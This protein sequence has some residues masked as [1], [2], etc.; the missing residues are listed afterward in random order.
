MLRVFVLS[1]IL[2]PLNIV[3]DAFLSSPKLSLN[4]QGERVIEFKI[5]S[6]RISDEDIILK[7]Y[8]SNELLNQ[9]N[10][11]Y[12]LLEDFSSYKTYSIVLNNSYDGNYFNFKLV[13][14]DQISKDIFIFLPSKLD[15]S[16]KKPKPTQAYKPAIIEQSNDVPMEILPAAK[17]IKKELRVIKAKEISTMWSLATNIKTDMS[18]ASIYQIMWSIYLGNKDAFIDGNINLVRNDKDL[19][20]PSYSSISETSH[21][22]AKAS[23][24]AM[25]ESYSL[26][27]APAVKSLLVLTAPKIIEA[28][29]QKVKEIVDEDEAKQL[30]INNE[31]LNDPAG[32]IK[33]NTKTLEMAFESKVAKELIKETEDIKPVDVQEFGLMDLLFVAF[34][35]I[36]SGILIAL[37]YIQLKSRQTKKIDYDFDEAPDTSSSVAGLPKGLSI[38]NN[39]EEQQLDLAVTY[40]EMGDL[41]NSKSI[42]DELMKST[43][44]DKIKNDAK[45][46]LDKFSEK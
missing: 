16:S 30:D 32:I 40:F 41:E 31:E 37:I 19:I 24:L 5:Q 13:I 26:S 10:I 2:L 21:T 12:T 18:D 11:S 44:S 33:N 27:I 17:E 34:V 3:A 46:L 38:R 4:S 42:L 39:E 6:A 45:T 25:N 20:I 15:S 14:E 29:E 9:E 35:S 23:I 7:E 1:L 36:L 43:Q 8:K 28:P 22:E